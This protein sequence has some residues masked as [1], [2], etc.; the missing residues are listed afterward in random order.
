[1]GRALGAVRVA[2]V[3]KAKS[4]KRKSKDFDIFIF[5]IGS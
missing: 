5:N 4:T 3:V 2:F 1:M